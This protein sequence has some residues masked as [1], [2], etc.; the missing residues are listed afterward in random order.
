MGVP[1]SEVGYISATAR[2][3]S[4]GGFEGDHDDD[5]IKESAQS[6]SKMFCVVRLP[7]CLEL[8]VPKT[9]FLNFFTV[10][11]INKYSLQK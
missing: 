2:R 11:E 3:G 8:T 4:C 1:N 9:V 5:R 10:V 7:Q 6:G